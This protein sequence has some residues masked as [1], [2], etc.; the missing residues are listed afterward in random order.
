VPA[1]TPYRYN[2][3]ALDPQGMEGKAEL[4]DGE[5][6]V[7]PYAGAAVKVKFKTRTGNALLIHTQ[8]A[9]GQKVPLGAE[10]Y[11]ESGSVIGMVGQGSQVYARSE[12]PKGLLTLRWGDDADER[13]TLPYDT[14]G[15]DLDQALIK[16]EAT[17]NRE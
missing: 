17:C 6:R 14:A 4:E 12:K 11:D 10:A 5:Q 16:L 3:V 9:D 13:C 2:S 8:L 7:A 15:K 1:V